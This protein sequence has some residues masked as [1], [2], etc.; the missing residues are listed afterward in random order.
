[1]PTIDQ[2]KEGY[3]NYLCDEIFKALND[4]KKYD[5]IDFQIVK[6]E[7]MINLHKILK[8]K[9]NFDEKVKILKRYERNDK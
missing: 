2:I 9:Q 6:V 7:L 4:A 3:F 1:M 5:C 8:N